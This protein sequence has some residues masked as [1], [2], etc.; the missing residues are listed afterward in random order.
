MNKLKNQSVERLYSDEQIRI[1]NE[2]ILNDKELKLLHSEIV[3][4]YT[5]ATPKVIMKENGE[6]ETVCIDE[7]NN[8]RLKKVNEIIEFRTNQIKSAYLPDGN[9]IS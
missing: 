5:L 9:K 1:C 3:K 7:T 4:I 8:L 2:A 6:I